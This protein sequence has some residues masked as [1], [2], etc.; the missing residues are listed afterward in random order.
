MAWRKKIV[1]TE[2]SSGALHTAIDQR[3]REKYFP[4]ISFFLFA[5]YSDSIRQKVLLIC[6]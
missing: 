6:M 4:G 5:A 1:A 3:P 2:S